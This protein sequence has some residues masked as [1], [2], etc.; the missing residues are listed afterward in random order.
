MGR[1]LSA[2]ARGQQQQF[3]RVPHLLGLALANQGRYEA[4]ALRLR[5]FAEIAG[6]S[7]ADRPSAG[8]VATPARTPRLR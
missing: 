3:P 7:D 2:I 8:R 1:E 4:A 6:D 5:G